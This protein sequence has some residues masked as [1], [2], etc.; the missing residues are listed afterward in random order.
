MSRI[1]Y[2]FALVAVLAAGVVLRAVEYAPAVVAPHPLSTMPLRVSGWTGQTAFFTPDVVAALHADDYLLR[3]YQ[4]GDGHLLAFYVAYYSSQPPDTRIHSPAVCLP[5]AGWYIARSG[6]EPIR[7]ADRTITV[8]RN[9]IQKGDMEQ[10][11]LYWFQMHGAVAASDVQALSL[12]A[13]TSLTQ[14]HSDEALVRI[15]A[16]IDGSVRQTVDREIAF[17]RTVFPSLRRA[18]P[19]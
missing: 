5:G 13:W 19:E 14:R 7:L 3:M 10:V 6:L 18:L 16:P 15:N 9:V 1:P 8:N 17:V 4:D 12:L 11:V 2:L